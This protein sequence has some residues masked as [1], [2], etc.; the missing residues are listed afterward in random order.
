MTKKLTELDITDSK[1][2]ILGRLML[3]QSYISG[4]HSHS[5]TLIRLSYLVSLYS[6]GQSSPCKQ[7][8]GVESWVKMHFFNKLYTM[9]EKETREVASF[10][11][12]S[13]IHFLVM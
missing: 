9:N 11:L 8:F 6:F 1:L 2:T 10:I 12:H 5:L 3:A 13:R 4:I 7:A